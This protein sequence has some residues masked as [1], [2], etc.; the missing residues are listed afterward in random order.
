[1]SG[2]S[3][4][5][6]LRRMRRMSAAEL[7]HRLGDEVRRRAWARRQVFPGAVPAPPPDLLPGRE[8]A[9]P[10]PAAARDFIF[11]AGHGN[12]YTLHVIQ[13]WANAH[14]L[15]GL[16]TIW[17]IRHYDQSLTYHWMMTAYFAVDALIH[18]FN[19]AG[20]PE[21]HA[22]PIVNTIPFVLFMA[23]GLARQWAE[24]APQTGPVI[25]A[26]S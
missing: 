24:K 6:Y 16:L 22:A 23:V 25:L 8:F 15:L 2:P 3:A 19:I 4:G 21:S 5:W 20:P 17:F 14:V 7:G 1:M 10:L 18:W 26:S 12:N 9:S 11:E 13:E